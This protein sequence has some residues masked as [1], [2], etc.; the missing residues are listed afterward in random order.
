MAYATPE[1][2]SLGC[3]TGVVLGIAVSINVDSDPDCRRD[4][5]TLNTPCLPLGEW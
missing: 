5:A 3:A 2:T 1:L 4:V